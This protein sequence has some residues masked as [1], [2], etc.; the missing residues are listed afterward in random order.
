MKSYAGETVFTDGN[1]IVSRTAYKTNGAIVIYTITPSSPFGE[2]SA[3]RAARGEKNIYGVVPEVFMACD[4]AA[5]AA[6]I[7][8][9]AAKGV[10]A[11]TASSSQGILLMIPEMFNSAGQLL[12][13]TYYIGARDVTR[14]SLTIFAGHSDVYAVRDTGILILFTK[15]AQEVQDLGA[16]GERLKWEVSLPVA[17]VY[18]GFLTSHRQTQVETL[19]DEFFWDFMPH[20]KMVAHKERSLDP[21]HPSV[22][23][24]NENPDG[25]MQGGLAQRPHYRAVARVLPR[26][27]AEFSKM[28]GRVYTPYDYHGHPEATDVIVA[29]GSSVNTLRPTI[30]WM[31]KQDPERRVG[32]LNVRAFRPF[33]VDDFI[34]TLPPTVER[35]AVLDR[36]MT[37]SAQD[38]PLCA[39]VRS[40][41]AKAVQGIDGVRRLEQMPIVTGGIYGLA[42]KNFHPG[43][44]LEVF[45]H[46]DNIRTTG[47]AW[48]GFTVGVHDDVLNTSLPPRQAPNIFDPEKVKQGRIVAFGSDGTVSMIKAAAEIW[49]AKGATGGADPGL[50]AVS[51]ADYDSKKAGGVTISHFRISSERLE[52]CFD[53]VTPDYVAVHHS[54]LLDGREGILDGVVEGGILVLN[55]AKDPARLFGSLPAEM[56]AVI[57]EKKLSVYAID[58][59]RIALEEGLGNKISMIMQR[60]LFDKFGMIDPEVAD[61]A[62]EESIQSKFGSKGEGVADRNIAAYRRALASIA[63]VV[64]PEG[65]APAT[66]D[67]AATAAELEQV[68]AVADFDPDDLRVVTPSEEG[69]RREIQRSG[70]AGRGNDV[71]VSSYFKHARGGA[72]PLNTWKDLSRGFAT[73]LPTFFPDKCNECG[74]CV[75]IC[76]TGG[77]LEQSL[78]STGQ[79]NRFPDAPLGRVFRHADDY[80]VESGDG[81]SLFDAFRI[82][83]KDA[84]GIAVDPNLCTG[85]G[86]CQ[87]VCKEDAIILE[88]ASPEYY[89]WLG[90]RR[91]VLDETHRAGCGTGLQLDLTKTRHTNVEMETLPS[92][93]GASGACAGCYEPLYVSKF[94]QLYPYSV[95]SNATGCSSIWG[96]QAYETPYS[97]DSYGYGA[98]W[99][100][101]LFE[102]NAA[103]GGGMA[104]GIAAETSQMNA[105][106]RFIGETIEKRPELAASD[107]IGRLVGQLADMREWSAEAPRALAERFE[108]VE[109]VGHL[110]KSIDEVL[111][112]EGVAG[113][114]ELRTHLNLLRSTI[115]NAIHKN[116]L[117]VGGDGWAFDIGL[118]MMI[119]MLQ[120]KLNLV[121]MVLVTDVYSNTGGQMSK[122]T[123]AGMDA[124]FAPGG[125]HQSRY[126][127][128]LSEAYGH[129]AYVAQVNLAYPNHL[130]SAYK[131]A[132]EFDGPSLLLCYVP[133]MTAQKFAADL[134]PDQ[135][136]RATTTR[137]WPLWTFDPETEVW[138][139][140]GN[141]ESRRAVANFEGSFTKDFARYEGRFRTQFDAEGN[142]SGLLL[143]QEE[144]NLRIWKLLQKNAADSAEGGAAPAAS[145]AQAA[146]S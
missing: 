14:H 129:N 109:L 83:H 20:D 113:D 27:M 50:F 95:I 88:P 68:G 31:L 44:V 80:S 37:H 144:E 57:L 1:E 26:I 53:V 63:P 117:I 82:E 143:S 92:Y 94:L 84:Y 77:A 32:V 55:S 122:A 98:A 33:L 9:A 25:Y 124:P 28:T 104:L 78:I 3:K 137:Y 119:H 100:N 134:V 76:P 87:S 86:I 67:V 38:E 52:E 103:V 23:G 138:S 90:D 97:S 79:L 111:G 16:I 43:S 115:T 89:A 11:A 45:D 22:W 85:C 128:G 66:I 30:S 74:E 56:Q 5:A 126:P 69:F 2:E 51:H 133:C 36:S 65:A 72:R 139:I 96:A 18:D 130:I 145:L 81:N 123:P 34:E 60:I 112:V 110:Q 116:T 19:P 17:V 40:A 46:L 58:A 21:A 4:E 146:V 13:I 8:G 42:G 93:V 41:V 132:A 54:A 108:R 7:Q 62:M 121:V 114:L 39:D 49:A 120:S 107:T 127:L 136:R 71:P 73:K 70:L 29:A 61:R 6:A 24:T 10:G 118:Q 131:R 135:S 75:S 142:P 47:K 106:A 101:P 141:P 105:S 99:M 64:I 12:P 15:D 48:T 102:N 125:K 59:F 35:I 140:E 91:D